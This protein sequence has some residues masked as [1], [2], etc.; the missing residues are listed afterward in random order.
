MIIREMD[1]MSSFVLDKVN[2]MNINDIK[3]KFQEYHDHWNYTYKITKEVSKWLLEIVEADRKYARKLEKVADKMNFEHVDSNLSSGLSIIK[4]I[5][6]SRVSTINPLSE[7]IETHLA[8]PLQEFLSKQGEIIK[9]NSNTAKKLIFDISNYNQRLDKYKERYIKS[10]KS[11]IDIKI[12]KDSPEYKQEQESLKMYYTAVDEYNSNIPYINDELISCL[13]VYTSQEEE[14]FKLLKQT[15]LQTL[16]F[17]KFYTRN[18]EVEVMEAIPKIENCK[19]YR[20]MKTTGDKLKKAESMN[21][22]YKNHSREL[23][24]AGPASHEYLM[25]QYIEILWQGDLPDED[26]TI[27]FLNQIRNL[28]GRKAWTN[29][30]NFRRSKGNF[31]IPSSSFELVG[32]CMANVFDAMMVEEDYS[33]AGLCIILADSFYE[34]ET[35]PKR[36]LHSLILSHPLWKNFDFWRELIE[37]S[38]ANNWKEYCKNGGAKDEEILRNIVTAQVVSYAHTMNLFKISKDDI[39]LTVGI[40][41]HKYKLNE[42]IKLLIETNS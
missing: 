30:L 2:I 27:R 26:I 40:F 7:S 16:Q 11:S 37:E 17:Q 13:G 28:E 5:L 9:E 32:D 41:E 39:L 8:M 12:T 20:D 25:T 1:S 15:L 31:E 3:F 10:C 36:F 18:F 33:M 34:A 14:R 6:N 42:D 23:A 22:L 21:G 29:G 4:S 38:V 19:L 24:R 35:E